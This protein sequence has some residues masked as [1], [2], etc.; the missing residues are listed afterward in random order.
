YFTYSFFGEVIRH[1]FDQEPKFE[2]SQFIGE[3][4][5]IVVESNVGTVMEVNIFSFAI[6]DEVKRQ[7]GLEELVKNRQLFLTNSIADHLHYTKGSAIYNYM[8][9]FRCQYGILSSY[10]YHWF[11]CRPVENPTELLISE[12]LS[13]NSKSPP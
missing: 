4:L 6:S 3:G 10:D 8:V 13:L 5:E 7:I 1:Q 11:L 2:R 12:A 9:S